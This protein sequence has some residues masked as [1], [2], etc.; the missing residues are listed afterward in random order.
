MRFRE[1]LH[2]MARFSGGSLFV[3]G[4]VGFV[5]DII[6]CYYLGLEKDGLLHISLASRKEILPISLQHFGILASG[7][8]IVFIYAK[9]LYRKTRLI[10]I[11]NTILL[12][13]IPL[14]FCYC[15]I[16]LPFF[17]NLME[18]MKIAQVTHLAIGDTLM[19]II[20]VLL[21]IP[22]LIYSIYLLFTGFK[23]AANVKLVWQSLVFGLLLFIINA[24]TQLFF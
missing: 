8:L 7:I 2:P 9:L 10:D 1:L 21:V 22:F 6:L 19:L 13:Q 12:S 17:E 14:I 23:L 11:T 15:I 24:I 4:I 18:K 20:S 16:K 5:V 3:I